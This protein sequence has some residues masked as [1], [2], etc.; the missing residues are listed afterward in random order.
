MKLRTSPFLSV[1][2]SLILLASSFTP[3]ARAQD[4]SGLDG[5]QAAYHDLLDL[6]YR[7]LDPTE[8]LRAGWSTLSTDADRRGASKPGPL[9]D[10]PSDADA[11]FV[12]FSGAYSNYVAS[13]PPSF[14][15]AMAAADVENGMADSVHE[16]H[17]HYLPPAVMQRFLSTVGGGQQSIGLGVRLG[18][19][20]P[21]LVTDVAPGGPAQ[22]AG[23]QAGDVIV[24]A[25]GKDLSSTDTPTLAAA[26]TGAQGST[27]ELSI[28]RGSG[29]V[30]ITVTRGPYYFPPL[31]SRVL[32]DGVGYLRLADFVISGTSLPN[33][34]ELLADLDRRLDEFDAQ[35]VQGLILD[36]R[37]NGG[38]SLQTTDELLGRFLPDT[39]RT[40]HELDQRGHETFELA[41]G[42]MHAR[43]LPMAVLINGGSASAS[44]VTA[45]ALRGAHRASLVGQ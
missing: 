8:L 2:F 21:G 29:P 35:G 26:L 13:L 43:Q 3:A 10:L 44:E 15:P 32:P 34:T 17:T 37:N 28:D 22:V 20:P 18:G 24:A 40:V 5:I 9:A 19:D 33:G 7:P 25:D 31:D 45:A 36:L 12:V 39:T 16:Q 23:L 42:R 30:S 4:G 11:A 41:G 38:G 6:F 14:T 27:V 1:L